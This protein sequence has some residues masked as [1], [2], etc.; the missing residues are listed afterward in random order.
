M[1]IEREQITGTTDATD[2]GGSGPTRAL[3]REDPSPADGRAPEGGR[4]S[5]RGP[6]RTLGRY[7]VLEDLRAGGM[8]LVSAAYGILQASV[9]SDLKRLL[10]YS[11]IEHMGIVALGAAIGGPLATAAATAAATVPVPQLHVSPT[12]RSHTRIRTWFGATGWTAGTSRS[13]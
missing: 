7:V 1:G 10:A 12:P 8:S 6:G 13:I 5:G 3:H 4:P 2:L 11:S 9:T